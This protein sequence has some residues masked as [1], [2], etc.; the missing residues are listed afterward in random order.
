M[1]LSSDLDIY[2]L[3]VVLV[4]G[5]CR[6]LVADPQIDSICFL[7]QGD[8]SEWNVGGYVC[9]E[10]LIL[11]SKIVV[12]YSRLM[13]DYIAYLDAGHTSLGVLDTDS[14]PCIIGVV[15]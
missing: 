8:S 4:K 11:A 7:F 12:F 14:H 2:V 10:I 15:S 1:L 6:M 13:R 3:V 5:S 9:E